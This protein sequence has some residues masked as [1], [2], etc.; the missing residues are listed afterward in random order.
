VV[1]TDVRAHGPVG[2]RGY[3]LAAFAIKASA[4][5]TQ[6]LPAGPLPK[7]VR[8]DVVA[9]CTCGVVV[10]D[11]LHDRMPRILFRHLCDFL[12]WPLGFDHGSVQVRT[13]NHGKMRYTIFA[14]LLVR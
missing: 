1:G 4:M 12:L 6:R 14:V 13:P 9:F 2:V 3:W 8:L 11:I 7:V 5:L 10:V